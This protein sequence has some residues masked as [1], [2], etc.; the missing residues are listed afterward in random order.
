MSGSNE[1]EGDAFVP[2][3]PFFKG[4]SSFEYTEFLKVVF[5][6]KS[7]YNAVL[8]RPEYK[9][10]AGPF[11]D[12]HHIFSRLLTDYWFRCGDLKLAHDNAAIT[13]TWTYRFN[14]PFSPEEARRAG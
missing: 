12:A 14:H 5:P 11:E 8:Q 2:E 10:P 13:D 4:M 7:T 9:A 6:D 1:N 3:I